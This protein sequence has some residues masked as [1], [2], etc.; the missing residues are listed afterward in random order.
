M[1][2]VGGVFCRQ[3][4]IFIVKEGI[5]IDVA[6]SRFLRQL[7]DIPVQSVDFVIS[8]YGALRGLALCHVEIGLQNQ[9]R[10]GLQPADPLHGGPVLLQ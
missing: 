5:D 2:S 1:D 9:N 3:V 8:E 6:A 10:G 4:P 7:L